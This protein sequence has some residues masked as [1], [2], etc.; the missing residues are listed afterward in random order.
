MNIPFAGL[1]GAD[2]TQAKQASG[3]SALADPLR[4]HNPPPMKK[5]P[6]RRRL[7]LAFAIALVSDLLSLVLVFALPVQWAVDAATGVALALILGARWELLLGLVPEAVPGVS[8]APFWVMD[9]G[10]IAWRSRGAKPGD[11]PPP[12]AT[13]SKA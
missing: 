5:T 6:S 3:I 1:N 8:L 7:A 4:G 10:L 13:P 12:Q 2:D 11:A 9:V